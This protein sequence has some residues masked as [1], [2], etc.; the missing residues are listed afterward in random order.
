MGSTRAIT[1]THHPYTSRRN[2]KTSLKQV[3][4]AYGGFASMYHPCPCTLH[5]TAGKNFLHQM[6][7]DLYSS[8]TLATI[9]PVSLLYRQGAR[10]TLSPTYASIVPILFS[11]ASCTRELSTAQ[12]PRLHPHLTE[13]PRLNQ[14]PFPSLPNPE[15]SGPPLHRL[16]WCRYSLAET[17]GVSWHGAVRDSNR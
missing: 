7:E 8:V 11:A 17:T 16:L 2:V 6:Y 15:T 3:P 12:V 4:C 5:E 10:G 9:T 1:Q 14:L 13:H